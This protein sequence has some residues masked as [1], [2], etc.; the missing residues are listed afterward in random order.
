[1]GSPP[2]IPGDATLI[3]TVDL[4]AINDQR[5]TRWMMSDMELVKASLELKDQGNAKFKERLYKEAEGIYRDAIGHIET[6][7]T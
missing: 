4:I 3:F 1:M 2:T 6:V 7:K 5:P